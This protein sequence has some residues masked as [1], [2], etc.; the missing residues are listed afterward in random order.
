MKG[1]VDRFGR[2]GFAA[3]TS[4]EA[5]V[6]CVQA[7]LQDPGIDVLLL[8]LNSPGHLSPTERALL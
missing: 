3:L 8:Q 6:Q 4:H 1:L 5:Y 2:T 7:M